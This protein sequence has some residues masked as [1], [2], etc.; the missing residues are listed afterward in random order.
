MRMMMMHD[1]PFGAEAP[2]DSEKSE[3]QEVAADV[4]YS[5]KIMKV[6]SVHSSNVDLG[7]LEWVEV[8][9]GLIPRHG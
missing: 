6:P 5:E 7:E 1:D 3:K 2:N 4:E 8:W 9:T